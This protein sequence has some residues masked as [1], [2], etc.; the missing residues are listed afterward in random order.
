MKILLL[1]VITLINASQISNSSTQ[2]NIETTHQFAISH[3]D[4]R[5]YTSHKTQH[6]SIFNHTKLNIGYTST[7][8]LNDILTHTQFNRINHLSVD[9]DNKLYSEIIF[10]D[11]D[12]EKKI[13]HKTQSSLDFWNALKQMDDEKN[14]IHSIKTLSFKGSIESADLFQHL[15]IFPQLT[16]LNLT[17]T[18]N[19]DDKMNA[20]INFIKD[21]KCPLTTLQINDEK[22]FTPME[23]EISKITHK[24]ISLIL[25]KN[26][27][28]K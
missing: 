26:T 7:I 5:I 11:L 16:T 1:I 23:S 10:S 19:T 13:F 8:N 12:N 15:K 17:D 4:K 28:N 3:E 6:I 24:K 20:L 21:D 22:L 18:L 14:S 27:D 9:P 25:K 2:N